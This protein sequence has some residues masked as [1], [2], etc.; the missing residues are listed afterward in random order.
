MLALGIGENS[1]REWRKQITSQSRGRRIMN[2]ERQNFKKGT[3][4]M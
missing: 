1:P 3:K 2:L 4:V